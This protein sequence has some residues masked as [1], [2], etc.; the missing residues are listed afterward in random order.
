MA[1]FKGLFSGLKQIAEDDV[2]GLV[3]V[4]LFCL[5][6]DGSYNNYREWFTQQILG[7]PAT[8]LDA[9]SVGIFNNLT[10]QAADRER[11]GMKAT[12]DQILW[13]I[14]EGEIS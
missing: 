14:R 13:K 10:Q 12:V 9:L 8:P 7:N 11:R 2:N 1:L 5:I 4:V 6:D 3:S